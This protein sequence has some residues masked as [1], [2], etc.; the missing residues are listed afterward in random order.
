MS[1]VVKNVGPIETGPQNQQNTPI[2]KSTTEVGTVRFVYQGVEYVW[3]PNEA[4]TLEDGIGAAAVA[5][6]ARLR[7]MDSRDH[8]G[9][10]LRT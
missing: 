8:A 9:T 10:A 4:K 3:G 2:R 7:V 5:A 1:I 6:D